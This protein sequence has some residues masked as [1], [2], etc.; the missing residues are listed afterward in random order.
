MKDRKQKHNRISLH[1]LSAEEVLGDVLKIPPEPDKKRRGRH[2]NNGSVEFVSRSEARSL[3][4]R[5]ARD[6]LGMSADEFV[7]AWNAGELTDRVEDP[8][9]AQLAMLMPMA[10]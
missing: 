3:F 5:L 6:Y 9:V 7:S 8:K 4:D 1:P 10:T 2:E